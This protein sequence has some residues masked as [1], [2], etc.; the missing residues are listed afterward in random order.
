[1]FIIDGISIRS[2]E[3]RAGGYAQGLLRDMHSS[4]NVKLM[5]IGEGSAAER[6]GL[7]CQK[8]NEII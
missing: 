6:W 7:V 8:Y 2:A 5:E 1:M 4:S 3:S